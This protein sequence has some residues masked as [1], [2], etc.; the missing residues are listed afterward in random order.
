MYLSY[1][2]IED[3]VVWDI[4]HYFNKLYTIWL[5]Q[6]QRVI[7]K[8]IGKIDWYQN[9]TKRDKT[10][11][12]AVATAVV[13]KTRPT[14]HDDVIK[15]KHFPRYRSFVWGIHRSPMDY[16]HKCQW[17]GALMFSL[18][19]ACIYGWVNNCKA[20]GVRRN[21]IHYDVTVMTLNA[22][23]SLTSTMKYVT[24]V[25]TNGW[26]KF[27]MTKMSWSLQVNVVVCSDEN[28]SPL[29]KNHLKDSFCKGLI[30][31]TIVS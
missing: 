13:L 26:F 16:P 23:K 30:K 19:C 5:T 28:N 22:R 9:A 27:L 29:P 31:Y 8:D 2:Y 6:Y 4:N 18:I 20:G 21:R 11:T 25:L 3:V 17:R 10:Q 24:L 12:A 15:G 1:H 14:A 7:L